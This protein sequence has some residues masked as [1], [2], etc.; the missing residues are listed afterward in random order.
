MKLTSSFL[1]NTDAA[2]AN[3]AAHLA[4]LDTVAQAATLA[5]AGGGR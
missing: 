2:R 3:R 5:A 4:M 1:P